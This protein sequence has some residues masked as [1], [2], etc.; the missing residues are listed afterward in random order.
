MVEESSET[1]WLVYQE[2]R[3]FAHSMWQTDLLKTTLPEP[4]HVPREKVGMISLPL[5][6]GQPRDLYDTSNMLVMPGDIKTRW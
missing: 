5:G 3:T 2:A 6:P 1:P 4:C